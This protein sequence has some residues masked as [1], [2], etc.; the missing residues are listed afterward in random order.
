MMRPRDSQRERIYRAE[1]DLSSWPVISIWL[2]WER[3][4]RLIT[5]YR[6]WEKR[7]GHPIPSKPPQSRPEPELKPMTLKQVRSYVNKKVRSGWFHKT[8]R[9]E[10]NEITVSGRKSNSRANC[11]LL[12]SGPLLSFPKWSRWPIVILH[13][14]AHAVTPVWC[15][16]H[17]PEFASNYIALVSHY[18]GTESARELKAAF[19]KHKASYRRSNNGKAG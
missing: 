13:E 2:S 5:Q 8:F 6:S 1:G 17:G 12:W 14:M 7:V 4:E 18:M 16:W 11:R 15:A 19:R 10:F 3:N 9:P